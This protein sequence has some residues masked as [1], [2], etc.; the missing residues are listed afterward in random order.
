MSDESG[1]VPGTMPLPTRRLRRAPGVLSGLIRL[2]TLLIVLVVVAGAVSFA[3]G[4]RP[5]FLR[6]PFQ[7]ETIDRS[8]P[9]VLRS[10]DTISQF[11]AA[12]AHMEVVVDLK[13]QTRYIPSWLSGEEVLFVGVGTVDSIVDFSHLDAQHVVVSPDRKSVTITLPS[14]T[15]G[16]PQLDLKH[17][18]VVAHQRGV[19]DRVG[20]FFGG[21]SADQ[22]VYL[23]A[24]QQMSTAA[25]ADGQV[26]TLG[27]S[28]TTAMLRGLLGALGF[29]AVTVTFAPDT[30]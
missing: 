16:Q 27:K 3:V 4:W 30:K 23:K 2:V 18:Y 20:N 24:V 6:N 25:A 5:S 19:L 15:I 9:A 13:D 10:L 17:S 8:Q 14:P 21:Q 11:H 1:Q 12:T 28:N 26:V 29:T 7:Q 22:P